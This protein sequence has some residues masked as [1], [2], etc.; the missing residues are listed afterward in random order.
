MRKEEEHVSITVTVRRVSG[1]VKVG[2]RR[3]R[4]GGV[5]W[6][7]V[8]GCCEEEEEVEKARWIAQCRT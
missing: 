6:G 5:L 3:A 7:A 2:R 1:A 8:G 4:L